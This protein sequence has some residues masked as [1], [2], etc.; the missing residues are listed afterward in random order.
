MKTMPVASKK[1]FSNNLSDYLSAVI[2]RGEKIQVTTDEGG[3]IV[4]SA[5][6]YNNLMETLYLYSIPGM[7]E[8]IENGIN[9]D[10]SDCVDF[11]WRK[12]LKD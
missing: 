12:E 10:L 7:K 6:E 11:D 2:S 9:T 4:M 3:A 1:D 8:K 5:D